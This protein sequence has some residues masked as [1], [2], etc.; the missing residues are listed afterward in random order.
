MTADYPAL[1]AQVAMQTVDGLAVMVLADS[2]EVLVLNPIGTRIL[3]LIDGK[4]SVAEIAGVIESEYTVSAEEAR[5]DLE[6]FLQ[7]LQ[8]AGALTSPANA[9]DGESEKL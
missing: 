9:P 5:R 4:R 6:T 1:A 8:E 7:T 2:G 3:E